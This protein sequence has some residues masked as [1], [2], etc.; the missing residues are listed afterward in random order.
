MDPRR[1]EHHGHHGSEMSLTTFPLEVIEMIIGKMCFVDLPYFL[2]T[3]KVIQV[4]PAALHSDIQN[5][6]AASSYHAKYQF[7]P[8]EA[9]EH[10]HKN[11]KEYPAM[12]IYWTV[13]GVLETY[14]SPFCQDVARLL[15]AALTLV[16]RLWIYIH[17]GSHP[18]KENLFVLPGR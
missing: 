13:D 10:I 18:G 8:K 14:T 4:D 9:R 3:S 7:I 2:Q 17:V 16:R 5:V 15:F 6:F 11:M 12:W 1:L